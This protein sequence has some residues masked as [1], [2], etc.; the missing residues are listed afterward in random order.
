MRRGSTSKIATAHTIHRI[1][2]PGSRRGLEFGRGTNCVKRVL[3]ARQPVVALAGERGNILIGLP[4]HPDVAVEETRSRG[5][6][7]LSRCTA[8]GEHLRYMEHVADTIRE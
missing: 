6:T 2:L 3:G 5:S 4:P 1:R 8:T 7:E